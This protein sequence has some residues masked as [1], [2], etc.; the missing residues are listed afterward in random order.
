[1]PDAVSGTRLQGVRDCKG[2]E[3]GQRAE[4]GAFAG[5]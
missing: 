3:R 2:E 5:G 4:R 1:V